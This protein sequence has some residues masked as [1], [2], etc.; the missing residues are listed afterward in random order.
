MHWLIAFF[1]LIAWSR[2][3]QLEHTE[4]PSYH[5]LSAL[6]TCLSVIEVQISFTAH[7][8]ELA[9]HIIVWANTLDLY[10]NMIKEI[11]SESAQHVIVEE[12]QSMKKDLMIALMHYDQDQV[13]ELV[14]NFVLIREQ[15]IYLVSYSS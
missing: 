6:A 12:Y 5:S 13:L 3:V 8:I 7:R 2:P 1:L 9:P 10:N 4:T 14:Q 15:C 11:Y